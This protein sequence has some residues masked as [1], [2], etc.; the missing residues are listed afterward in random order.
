[1]TVIF[2]R[3]NYYN[4]TKSTWFLA[5]MVLVL[6]PALLFSTSMPPWAPKAS[7]LGLALLYLLRSAAMG[8]FIGQTPLDWPLLLLLL[9]LLIG[10]Q[11]SADIFVS[12][13][14]TYSMIAYV[15][16]F[17]AIAVQR[18]ALWLR[19]SGWLLL[20]TGLALAPVV[21]L[22]TDFPTAKLSFINTNLYQSLPGGLSTFWDQKGFNP[23]LSGGLLALFWM[24]A[25]VMIW[26]GASW[27]E[28]DL[29]K[30]VTIILSILLV[31]TQSRGGLLGAMV[32][33]MVVTLLHSRRWLLFWL[34]VLVIT[35]AGIYRIGPNTAFEMMF[36]QGD[37]LSDSSLQGRQE[38]WAVAIYLIEEFP[39][40]GVGLGVVESYILPDVDIKHLHNLYLQI[41]AEMGIFSLISHIAIYLIIFFLLLKQALNQRSNPYQGLALGLLGSLIIFLTHGMFDVITSSP[42]VAIVVW[43]LL[44]LM[45]AVATS[46]STP[47]HL[48]SPFHEAR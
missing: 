11:N 44:G 43:P 18:N 23:N 12:L 27:Q 24:P 9:T 10:L 36:R 28:R 42:R 8:H 39:L 14:K 26:M 6:L 35:I 48:T 21:L 7:L 13:P 30:I 37:V 1:M 40:T 4:P 32:A 45:V 25:V 31:L 19:W 22:F 41:G 15:A 20:L 2:Q 5:L 29:A 3:L 33:L 16:L 17:W 38:L 34:V 47:H 46:S